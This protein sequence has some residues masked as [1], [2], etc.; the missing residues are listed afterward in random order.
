MPGVGRRPPAAPNLTRAELLLLR[1]LCLLGLL[2]RWHRS[3]PPSH[4]AASSGSKE[5]PLPARQTTCLAGA[6]EPFLELFAGDPPDPANAHRWYAG[7]VGVLHRAESAQ[8]RG[9]VDAETPRHL[10]RG[11]KLVVHCGSCAGVLSERHVLRCILAALPALSSPRTASRTTASARARR[12]RFSGSLSHRE[13]PLGCG[14][15][16]STRS[17]STRLF[18]TT[19][20]SGTFP[21]NR[22]IASV[23]TRSTTR[24]RTSASSASSHDAHS[25]I[26]GGDGRRSPAP[27]AA[28]P[29]KHFVIAVRYGRCASSTP[30]TA[31]HRRS[32]APA[33]PENGRPVVSSTAPGA[34]PM[35]IMRSLTLPATIGNADG[36]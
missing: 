19:S 23:P 11:Q 18:P 9:G 17:P 27:L 10:V 31:S 20:L 8:D 13:A 22:S 21:Q 25:W 35:I 14:S 4:F 33:R 29:G 28:F 30:A 15:G 12:S 32:S 5:P 34:W 6:S 24:G 26:S 3:S 36:R 2:L 16:M 1:L 7:R